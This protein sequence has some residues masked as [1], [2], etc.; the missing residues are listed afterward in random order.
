MRRL[1]LF[2]LLF[3]GFLVVL[4]LSSCSSDVNESEDAKY[5]VIVSSNGM[6]LGV[7]GTMPEVLVIPSV[8]NGVSV[9]GIEDYAFEKNPVIKKVVLP[10]G[11]QTIGNK[12]FFFC[13]SLTQVIL[14][15]SIESIGEY[16]FA[17]C[18]SLEIIKLDVQE[19]DGSSFP[20]SLK[21]IGDWAFS[22]CKGSCSLSVPNSLESIGLGAFSGWDNLESIT[23]PY[24]GKT[25]EIREGNLYVPNRWFG[26]IFGAKD[27]AVA[28][29]EFIPKKLQEVVLTSEVRIYNLS[30]EDCSGLRRIVIPAS[31]EIID[32]ASFCGCIELV[33]I[34]I[35]PNNP[36]YCSENGMLFD[37]N[38]TNLIC[39]PS[40]SGDVE[41]PASINQ[42]SFAAFY[43]C[44]G[45]NSIVIPN[46]ITVI[47]D[48]TFSGCSSLTSVSI[49]DS[50]TSIGYFA[51]GGCSMLANLE[52]PDSVTK[53]SDFAFENCLGLTEMTIPSTVTDLG[54]QLFRGC[55]NLTSVTIM[56]ST[57][58]SQVFEQ[59]S[60]TSILFSEGCESIPSMCLR[61]TSLTSITI[62]STVISIGSS[63][64][65]GCAGLSSITFSGTCSQWNSV[66]KADSWNREVPATVVQC[67]DGDV[68]I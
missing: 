28:Q 15:A 43:G 65:E 63:A 1:H 21:T 3:I 22:G 8:V 68:V 18:E 42:I 58:L 11:V 37:I 46:T 6:V 27:S 54:R 31:V 41:I 62:P 9:V 23:I 7:S 36:N 45:L 2:S 17:D 55:V 32:D 67:S 59:S 44:T 49:P 56:P 66:S 60:V 39:Y 61:V 53:I 14:P 34:A 40:A 48:S 10:E 38:K 33:D 24:V 20:N 4:F 19:S 35:D 50:V 30:F 13:K 16:A 51:F 57:L 64:F 29:G 5:S 25:S 52:I 12:S 26:Y 47:D